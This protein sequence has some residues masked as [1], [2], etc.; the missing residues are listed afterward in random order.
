[1]SDI[2]DGGP[3]MAPIPPT[4]GSRGPDMAPIPPMLGSAPAKPWRSSGR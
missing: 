4:L 1:M 2:Q 3:D